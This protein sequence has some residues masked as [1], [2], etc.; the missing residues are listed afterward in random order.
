MKNKILLLFSLVALISIISCKKEGVDIE[1]HY[2]PE[3]DYQ[4]MTQYLNLEPVPVSYENKF[5][6]YYSSSIRTYDRDM[7]TLGRVLFYDINLSDDRSISCAS[8]HRQDIGFSDDKALSDGVN[9][10]LTARNSLA[11]GS[12]FSFNEYYGSAITGRVPFF[13]DN[14]AN[15]V[16]EQSKATLANPLEM[17]MDMDQV[18]TRVEEQPYYKPLFKAA[19]GHEVQDNNEILD[20]IAVFVNSIGSFHTRYDQSVDKYLSQNGSLNGIANSN[21]P[22][23]SQAEE[24]GR[25]LYLANCSS[26]HGNIEEGV[27][28]PALI[29]ANN[30]LASDYGDDQG[31]GNY[32]PGNSFKGMFKVPTLRNIEKTG[33]YM[34]DGR[35]ATLEDV[36][37][38]YST[39]VQDHPNLS[40][41]LKSSSNQPVRFNYTEAEKA[42]LVAFLKTYTDE[43]FLTNDKYSDPFK[44]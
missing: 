33:P 19:F 37:D 26:C 14:R 34:H 36:I 5:P 2:Y 31:M 28:A 24:N 20:A 12:V 40:P 38:H 1:Y 30:G 42:D 32:E 23:F 4:M 35:F 17:N 29:Q 43:E 8:C 10:T 3:D 7:A 25:R 44:Q 39:G 21:M 16:Q 22:D 13:W 6:D 41:E 15:S 27:G 11:L 9:N 18:R